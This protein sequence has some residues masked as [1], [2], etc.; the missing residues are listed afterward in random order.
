MNASVGFV[1]TTRRRV[2]G[3]SVRS[4]YDPFDRNTITTTV[5]CPKCKL[6]NTFIVIISFSRDTPAKTTSDTTRTLLSR[7]H[8]LKSDRYV[9]RAENPRFLSTRCHSTGIGV[10]RLSSFSRRC[11]PTRRVKCCRRGPRSESYGEKTVRTLY[12]RAESENA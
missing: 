5:V 6:V 3:I 12:R 9:F 10:T 2:F 8:T 1:R 11:S 7:A 4:S